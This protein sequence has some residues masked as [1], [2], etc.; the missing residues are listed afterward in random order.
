LEW[1]QNI[2][3]FRW[4]EQRVNQELRSVMRGAWVELVAEAKRYQCSFR[5]AAFALGVSRVAN[6]TRLRGL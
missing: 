6:A 2:Q 5:D 3:R 4:E 1:V